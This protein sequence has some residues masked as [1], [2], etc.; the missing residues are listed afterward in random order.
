[1]QLPSFLCHRAL[2]C[3]QCIPCH[4]FVHSKFMSVF[5]LENND[6]NISVS[7]LGTRLITLA[8]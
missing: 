5:L 3:P 4:F 6:R 1:M 8:L 7:H 2:L